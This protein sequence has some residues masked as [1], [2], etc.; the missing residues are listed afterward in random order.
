M[1]KSKNQVAVDYA[2]GAF[3]LKKTPETYVGNLSKTTKKT[4]KRLKD[5][6]S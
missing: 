1:K 2:A 6:N 3:S 4:L 5:T